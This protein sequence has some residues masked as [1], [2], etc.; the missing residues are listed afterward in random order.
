MKL[1]QIYTRC[2]FLS[3]TRSRNSIKSNRE[4]SFLSRGLL[5]LFQSSQLKELSLKDLLDDDE[6]L[7]KLF[8]TSFAT[9]KEDA[10]LADAKIEMDK[11]QNCLDVFVTRNGTK[12]EPVIG[13]LT[14]LII[15]ENAKV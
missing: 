10:N 8:E 14:N 6:E 3:N 1:P 5:R 15:T 4:I 13:W 9:V 2:S 11:V 7:R 12:N